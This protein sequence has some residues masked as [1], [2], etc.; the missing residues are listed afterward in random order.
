VTDN[1]R[2]LRLDSLDAGVRLRSPLA[3]GDNAWIAQS[4]RQMAT[5]LEAQGDDRYRVAAYRQAGETVARLSRSVREVFD[6]AGERR[7][8]GLPGIG[9]HIVAAIDEMLDSGRWRRLE[10]FRGEADPQVLLR[11]VPGVGADLAQQL[12]QSMGIGTLRAL[13]A[14][15]EEGRLGRLPQ[16]GVQRAAAI[17]AALTQMLDRGRTARQALPRRVALPTPPEPPVEWLLDVD[18]EYRDAAVAGKLPLIA[19]QRFNPQRRAWLAVLHT[20]RGDW[21]FTVLYANTERVHA[22]GRL[23]DW[24]VISAKDLTLGERQYLVA[25]ACQGPLL[26]RRE[27]R[28]RE[29]DCR[30]WY[31]QT[32][33]ADRAAAAAPRHAHRAVH[34]GR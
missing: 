6:S 29:A 21:Q 26:G 30:T 1:R 5:L 17:G 12:H 15:V 23:R 7:A 3:C 19:P 9:P 32:P 11:T 16:V 28:G 22:Q 25:T 33:V 2:E 18:S 4:L 8:G 13:Q 14:A 24:V 20:Q 27:V 31:R 10:Q 34:P